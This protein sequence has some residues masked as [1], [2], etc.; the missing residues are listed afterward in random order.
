MT[1]LWIHQQPLNL[2]MTIFIFQNNSFNSGVKNG[3]FQNL[4][5]FS[6]PNPKLHPELWTLSTGS[7]I[8]RWSIFVCL[9]TLF[10]FPQ[11]MLAHLS[12]SYRGRDELMAQRPCGPQSLGPS[13][14]G[15]FEES[16]PLTMS[17]PL[18]P[19][20]SSVYYLFAGS[21]SSHFCSFFS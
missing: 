1:A 17:R 21:I 2:L 7:N 8:I 15:S 16:A 9:L 19:R 6:I 20:K 4:I 18:N 11:K 5:L 14:S 13:L 12:Q 3:Y 10:S